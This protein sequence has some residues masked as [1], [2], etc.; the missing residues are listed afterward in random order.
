MK[1]YAPN[2]SPIQGTLE[3]FQGR[4]E[5]V[6]DSY[7]LDPVTGLEFEYGGYT[8]VF[9]DDQESVLDANGERLFL[10]SDGTAWPESKLVLR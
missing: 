2:G 8:E 5:I 9:W 3:Q 1:A 6:D 4:A 7:T 10:A